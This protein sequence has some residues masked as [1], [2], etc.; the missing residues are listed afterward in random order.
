[1]TGPFDV[2]ARPLYR[3]PVEQVNRVYCPA[4]IPLNTTI[5]VLGLAYP[6]GQVWLGV[7][8]WCGALTANG[9][10]TSYVTVFATLD[11]AAELKHWPTS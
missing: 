4:D 7:S 8:D 2:A 5:H 10:D 1:L 6:A 11:R 3:T 9:T